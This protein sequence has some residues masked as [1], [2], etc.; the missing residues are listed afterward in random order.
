VAGTSPESSAHAGRVG[1]RDALRSAA[2]PRGWYVQAR[3]IHAHEG[4]WNANTGNGYYGGMQFLLSTWRSVGGRS[5]PD[6]VS[7][8]EQLYRAFLVW[9]RDGGSWRE[10]GTARLCGLR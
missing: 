3:C 8:A 7:P 6:L 5:R 10:W 2:P 4:A 9:R 1:L